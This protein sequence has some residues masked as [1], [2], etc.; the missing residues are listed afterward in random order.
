MTRHELFFRKLAC[1]SLVCQLHAAT[2]TTVGTPQLIGDSNNAIGI[3]WRDASVAK[4][5]DADGDNILGSLGYWLA[6]TNTVPNV[7]SGGFDTAQM[8]FSAPAWLTVAP[9]DS[10]VST[11]LNYGYRGFQNPV[12]PTTKTSVGYMGRYWSSTLSPGTTY[13]L[14]SFTIGNGAPS[15]F[16]LTVATHS[17][18]ANTTALQ[19]AQ[20]AGTGTDSVLV[21]ALPA[22]SFTNAV[23]TTFK[24]TG[25]QPGDVFQLGGQSSSANVLMINALM[26]DGG[27]VT[28]P[29][30]N[31]STQWKNI[32]LRG[33]GFVTGILTHPG[34]GEI[35]ART[36]VAGIFRWDAPSSR[37]SALLDDVSN[38]LYEVRN[39]ES[40]ALDPA[41]ANRFFVAYGAY[42]E[43]GASVSPADGILR[44]DDKGLTWTRMNLPSTVEMGG[45]SDWRHCGERLVVDP[46]N[47]NVVY[48]GSRQDGLWRS[49]DAGLNWTQ[50][51]GV[52]LGGSNG[53][54][55]NG[56]PVNGGITFVTLNPSTTTTTNGPLR[57]SV[58]Y[59]GIMD[60]GVYRSSDG[61][62]TFALLG[63]QPDT[64]TSPMQGRLA[65][66]GTLYVTLDGGV[67]RWRSD[68][69]TDITP[70][71]AGF[72]YS[73][74]PWAGLAVDPAN[75]NRLAINATGTSP[76]DL[77]ISSDAGA[78]WIIHTT[79]PANA[80]PAGRHKPVTFTLPSWISEQNQKFSWSGAMTF[81][82]GDSNQL[83]V[84]TG[85]AVYVYK[86]LAATPV[87]ADS[88]N[89]MAGFEELV[90]TRVLPLPAGGGGGVLAGVMDQSG[91]VIRDP[92]I[93]PSFHIGNAAIAN[94]TGLGISALTNTLVV[95][96]ASGNYSEG[97]VLASDDGGQTWRSLAKP[98]AAN[99]SSGYGMTLGGDIAVSA[100][101]KN[102]FV[103]I[104]LN[105]SWYPNDHPPIYSSNGGTSWTPTTGLPT[106][107]NS[108]SN[109]YNGQTNVLAAD[110]VNGNVFYAYYE[111]TATGIGSMYRS[112]DGGANWTLRNAS[113][114]GYWRSILLARPG[115]E[116]EVWY[117]ST[118]GSLNRSSDGGATFSA[119]PGWTSVK[120]FGFGAP[121][122]GESKNTLYALGTRTGMF[123]VYYSVDDG[124]TWLQPSDFGPAPISSGSSIS[125]D[126]ARP[127][128]IYLA[129]GGRGLF[130]VDLFGSDIGTAP[131]FTNPATPAQNPVLSNTTTLSALAADAETPA[132]ALTYVWSAI[133]TPPGVS[134][135]FSPNGN[136]TAQNTTATFSSL[137][138]YTLRCTATDSDLR[139]ATSDV[140]VTLQGT[141][142]LIV[143][144][145]GD[146]TLP[147]DGTQTYHALG[148]TAQGLLLTT[149]PTVPGA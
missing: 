27:T 40:F 77:L 81:A 138:T 9:A 146:L 78:T 47:S 99:P 34:T 128:R 29:V 121:L 64:A 55:R 51:A 143:V 103:W 44:T 8:T 95:S 68:T 30:P 148:Y 21:S 73:S 122:P 96:L 42:V 117:A 79:D 116:G 113:L 2:V 93:T 100:T 22:T 28:P 14:Y 6:K 147:L 15:E 58:V 92:E 101:N 57:S 133:A 19:L 46:A 94:S 105:P 129:S 89:Y 80:F 106:F 49:I 82:P 24:I 83:W 26:V 60:D 71:I 65:S 98:F 36:D 41:N 126:L 145:P 124:A 134:V 144:Q 131:V 62:N 139:S 66:D 120:A 118:S 75:P 115:S 25:A 107:F 132:H 108:L 136:N 53:A 112:T 149:P 72:T 33:M 76:R 18:G 104:P 125:G 110:S 43:D 35:Y 86:N 135:I 56:L 84:T 11:S 50:I 63:T 140:N 109:T 48:F 16:R 54:T 39:V 31:G 142:G 87:V 70:P 91:F 127:G 114:P 17:E 52:P 32:D 137:G 97:E 102:N 23:F 111:N 141:L 74:R 85:F 123:G 119:S 1:V 20:T 69:W 12:T 37:W 7:S 10:A 61:G 90:G 5:N 59:L 3:A 67:W 38:T 4:T 130:Y 88:R 13:S 45:N